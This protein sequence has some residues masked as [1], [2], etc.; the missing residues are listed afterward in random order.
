[1]NPVSLTRSSLSILAR[2]HSRLVSKATKALGFG[3]VG[4]S[5]VVVNELVLWLLVNRL[6]LHYLLGAALATVGSTTSNFV[7]NEFGVFWFR[8][9]QGIV[10]RYVSFGA[11]SVVL[12][13]ARLT[14]LFLLTSVLG[15]HYLLANLVALSVLFLVRFGISDQFIW[16]QQAAPSVE[17][18]EL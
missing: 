8:R 4:A 3:L 15:V 10:K 7:L 18:A 13:P 14:V 1:M 11:L 6:D 16:I 9:R 12:L 5:G 17:V 2:P